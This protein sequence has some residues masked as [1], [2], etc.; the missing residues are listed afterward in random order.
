MLNKFV[1]VDLETT[2]NLPQKGDKIIQFAA[3]VIENGKI[4]DTFSSFLN[5]QKQIPAFIEELTGLNNE[6]VQD[7]PLFSE[8]APKIVSLLEN[9]YFVAHNVLFDL[10]FLQEELVQAGCEGFFGPVLDTVELARILYPTADGYKLTELAEMENLNHERPHQADSDAYVTAELLLL[11]F[12][13][14]LSLP[15]NTLQYLKQL[16]GGLKSDIQQLLDE[17][18]IEKNKS[19]EI[20]PTS[21]E[22]FKGIVIKKYQNHHCTD[23]SLVGFRF[24]VNHD[25]KAKILQKALPSFEKRSAQFQMMDHIFQSF[26]EER[27]ALVEAGTGIGKTIGYLLPAAFFSKEKNAPIVISTF[28]IQLQEQLL[29]K[30]I[31]LLLKMVP[32]PV[33]AVLLKGRSHY[34]SL[35]KFVQTLPNEND[36]YDTTLT[37]MQILIWLLETETGDQDEL[38]LSSGG[39][40]YWN[41][42]KNDQ[43]TFQLS[44]EWLKKDYYLR[45]RKEA[46]NADII[47]TNHS[48]LLADLTNKQKV[49]PEY[50]Y[51]VLDEGHHFS[52][53][54]SKFFGRSIDYLSIRMLLSQLGRFEDRQLFYKMEEHLDH[55]KRQKDDLIHPFELNNLI[56]DLFYEVDEFFKL[57]AL[58]AKRKVKNRKGINRLRIR[59][60]RNEKGVD[61]TALI[62]SAERCLFLL[63][64]IQLH[65][66]QRVRLINEAVTNFSNE[67]LNDLDEVLALLKDLEELTTNLQEMVLLETGYTRWIEIDLR[68]VQNVTTIYAQPISIADDL[69]NLF[70]NTKKGVVITSA[71]LTVNQSFDF[72]IK[73]L[74][75]DPHLLNV[76]SISSPF[77]YKNQVKLFIPEDLPEI[78]AVSVDEYVISITEQIISLAEATKGRML[79]LFT[80]NE[81]LQKTY[82]LIKESGFLSEFA[83]LAQGIT[84]GS[85]SRLTRYFQKYEKA[86]LLGSSSFWEGIDIPGQNLSCLV[87]VR[88]PFSPPDEPYTEAKCE[89]ITRNGGNAFS[90]YSLPEAV[91]KFKQGFGRLIR[92][93]TDRGVIIVFDKRIITTKYGKSFLKSIPDVDVKSGSVDQVVEI[94]KEWL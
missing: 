11:F 94:I 77:D 87:I 60:S 32:F 54:A 7:A 34:I 62:H 49:L 93:E 69:A 39:L 42:I 25:E 86:I 74:G 36:N 57:T 9:S 91:L 71:T 22:I 64:D 92:T 4:I 58:F 46:E 84:S 73:E 52:K 88:L 17:L 56:S 59:L 79:I 41:K 8:I 23:Q 67:Q 40:L 31:P 33:K 61:V 72:I 53:A 85:R 65:L 15:S 70:F 29:K 26:Q 24:P 82:E 5:P 80:S 37:K 35:K 20:L 6:M 81:M 2:G 89:Y 16:S 30:E 66:N 1:V 19:V 75:L 14:L 38:N 12:K 76:L 51:V 55:V 90:E 13:K 78:K 47:I 18:L 50:Q 10:S 44:G 68:S 21:L 3:V 45:A 28:T 48:L 27:H 63:K 83:I 43:V